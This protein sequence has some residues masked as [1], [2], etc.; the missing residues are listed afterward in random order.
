MSK[1]LLLI[2]SLLLGGCAGSS[3]YYILSNASQPQS[4]TATNVGTVGVEKV[5]VPKYLFKRK[6]AVANSPHEIVFLSGAEWGEDMDEGLTRRLI[7]YLRHHFQQPNIFAYPWGM[8]SQ[9]DLKVCVDITRFI[10]QRGKVYLDANWYIE[11]LH[12][13]RKKS[14]LFSTA[15]PTGENAEAI[16]S[17]M[18]TAFSRLEQALARDL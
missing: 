7:A 13:G 2:F 18:D 9:P 8:D 15:V 3:G 5:H 12:T 1:I 6:I 16:V 11:D 4:R 10:A 14:R 17:A